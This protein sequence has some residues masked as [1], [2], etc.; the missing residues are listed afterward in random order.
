MFKAGQG[1]G[2]GGLG[3]LAPSLEPANT[4][5]AQ[6]L[7]AALEAFVPSKERNSFAIER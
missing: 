1:A 5:S 7:L 2:N 3:R 4:N 6:K